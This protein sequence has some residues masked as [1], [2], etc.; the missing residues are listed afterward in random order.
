MEIRPIKTEEEYR[1]AMAEIDELLDVEEGTPGEEKL[2]LLSILVEAYEDVHYPIDPPDSIEAI[3]FHMEQNGLTRK[4]MEF[5]I[6]PRQR[7]ADV[8][9]RK[10]PLS[11]NMIRKLHREL[12]IPAEILIREPQLSV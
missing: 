6:G 9:N 8:L 4:D 7:V 5:Y 3:K 12:G 2:E 10:R 11:L 1:A